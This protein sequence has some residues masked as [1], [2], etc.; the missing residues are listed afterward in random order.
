M[1]ILK[2]ELADDK[3]SF[4]V[5]SPSTAGIYRVVN[6]VFSRLQILSVKVITLE[7]RVPSSK[8]LRIRSPG[9]ES[10]ISRT[11]VPPTTPIS[12]IGTVARVSPRSPGMR[13]SG[14]NSNPG[15]RGSPLRKTMLDERLD[16]WEMDE[17]IRDVHEKQEFRKKIGTVLKGT[18]PL[19]TEASGSM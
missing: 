9:D 13:T 4:G 15:M 18:R 10:A 19:H 1:T 12:R 6:N 11:S 5:H 16:P 2:A 8:G 17:V 7:K 3:G 14:M